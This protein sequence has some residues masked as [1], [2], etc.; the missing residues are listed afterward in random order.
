MQTN[1]Q[2]RKGSTALYENN[3]YEIVETPESITLIDRFI[4]TDHVIGVVKGDRKTAFKAIAE[5]F[6]DH[7]E[8]DRGYHLT[9]ALHVLNYLEE[10]ADIF[11]YISVMKGLSLETAIFWNW[12]YH[13]HGEKALKAFSVIYLED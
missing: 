3:H 10:E 7:P 9:L 12:M 6:K 1:K 2:M 13:S 4:Y 5:L 8:R 11:H